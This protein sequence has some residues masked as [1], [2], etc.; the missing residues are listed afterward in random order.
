VKIVSV[1]MIKIPVAGRAFSCRPRKAFFMFGPLLQIRVQRKTVNHQT[2]RGISNAAIN[3]E[4]Y[5]NSIRFVAAFAFE[6]LQ[7]LRVQKARECSMGKQITRQ[8]FWRWKDECVR[9]SL[10]SSPIPRAPWGNLK[11]YSPP[12]KKSRKGEEDYPSWNQ[13]VAFI[14]RKPSSAPSPLLGIH[15]M[16]TNVTATAIPPSSK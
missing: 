14:R 5:R 3:N 2:E 4:T 7:A 12:W 11:K 10:L 9:G 16:R 15:Q 13:M 8:N 1:S 6:Y